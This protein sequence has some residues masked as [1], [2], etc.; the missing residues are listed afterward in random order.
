MQRGSAHECENSCTAQFSCLHC[1]AETSEQWK[2]CISGAAPDSLPD[3]DFMSSAARLL[4]RCDHQI[5]QSKFECVVDEFVEAYAVE[6]LL[7]R[8]DWN[9]FL[10]FVAFHF[11]AYQMQSV[12]DF[13]DGIYHGG[14][15]RQ[16]QRTARQ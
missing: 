7:K 6:D 13:Q 1:P 3:F 5:V 16:D 4:T 15:P 8:A 9:S 10:V 14:R 2:C 11:V 12:Q